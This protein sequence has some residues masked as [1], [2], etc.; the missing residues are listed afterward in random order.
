[1][2]SP[3]VQTFLRE[4]FNLIFHDQRGHGR[5]T[6]PS[7]PKTTITEMADDIAIILDHLN[8][9]EVLAV[10]GVSQGGAVALSFGIRHSARTRYIVACDTQA[11]T[12]PANIKAWDDRLEVARKEGMEVLARATAA[13]W[14]PPGS[15]YHP[16]TQSDSSDSKEKLQMLL[17][18]MSS[19]PLLGF[20]AG[21]RALQDYDL[22]A[23]GLLDIGGVQTL[24]IAGEK[25]GTLPKVLKELTPKFKAGHLFASFEQIAGSG[26]LPML[27][28]PEEFSRLVVE[29]I[30]ANRSRSDSD[31]DS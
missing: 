24:L 2:W 18:M 6:I 7:P 3:I 31:S 16:D 14:F 11:K 19:T 15:P 28:N 1:M 22:I 10:V 13:R 8:I 5:S 25:D 9:P 30:T 20:E 4:Y 12:P 29:L 21:A 27:D 23:D 26:H 17:D